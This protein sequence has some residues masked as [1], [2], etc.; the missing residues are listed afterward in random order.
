[1]SRFPPRHAERLRAEG[2]NITREDSNRQRDGAAVLEPFSRN[3][4]V[5]A[6]M[7]P[8]FVLVIRRNRTDSYRSN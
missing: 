3:L 7:S 4:Q 6:L 5:L 2:A 8:H 1:M